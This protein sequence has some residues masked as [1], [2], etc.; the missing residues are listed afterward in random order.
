M[1]GQRHD[2]RSDFGLRELALLWAMGIVA[3]AFLTWSGGRL[4]WAERVTGCLRTMYPFL[5]PAYVWSVLWF[6]ALLPL[7]MTKQEAVPDRKR[8]GRLAMASAMLL[9]VP[10]AV[11]HVAAKWGRQEARVVTGAYLVWCVAIAAW[12]LA[13][14]RYLGGTVGRE[15]K[16]SSPAAVWIGHGIAVLMLLVVF[17]CSWN[18]IGRR[19]LVD[20]PPGA[21]TVGFFLWMGVMFYC[22]FWMVTLY[23]GTALAG[24]GIWD[25]LEEAL[26]PAFSRALPAA[27]P[28]VLLDPLTTPPVVV[29]VLLVLTPAWVAGVTL[30]TTRRVLRESRCWV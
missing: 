15:V 10:A 18:E 4:D 30:A 22:F 29:D 20:V 5:L 2:E 14:V 12:T 24:L 7:T 28:L 8:M 6:V 3:A 26:V 19:R 17:A 1:I 13:S 9:F 23:L 11:L 25:S 27:F 21:L 16:A